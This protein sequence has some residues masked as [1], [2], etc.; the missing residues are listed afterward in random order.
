MW[1]V[2]DQVPDLLVNTLAW[3]S[4]RQ[5]T[6]LLD[7]VVPCSLCELQFTEVTIALEQT[8]RRPESF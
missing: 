5:A 4:Y 8:T 6:L 7:G 1:I 3:I 2:S